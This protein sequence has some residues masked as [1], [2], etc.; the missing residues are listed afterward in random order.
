MRFVLKGC[1]DY[2]D[3]GGM[4]N[5]KCLS[6]NEDFNAEDIETALVVA[7]A[8]LESAK[9]RIGTEER[10]IEKFEAMLMNVIC[11]SIMVQQIE[12]LFY[13]RMLLGCI[14]KIY[15]LN[16][17]DRIRNIDVVLQ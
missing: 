4:S 16:N 15:S 3:M 14:L 1:I 13:N 5:S 7:R 10:Y 11:L 12:I 8:M 6:I 17:L 2:D 9:R